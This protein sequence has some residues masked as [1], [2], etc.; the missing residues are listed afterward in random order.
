MSAPLNE[1]ASSSTFSLNPNGRLLLIAGPCVLETRDLAFQIAESLCQIA[2][3]QPIQLVFKAS[4]DKANRTSIHSYRGLGLEE[5]LRSSSCAR[6][7]S[8]EAS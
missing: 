6:I 4:F 2:E 1:S 3:R 7:R 5:G 8:I